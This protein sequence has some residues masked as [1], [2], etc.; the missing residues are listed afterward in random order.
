MDRLQFLRN[1]PKRVRKASTSTRSGMGRKMVFRMPPASA[2]RARE[3]IA[4]D[5]NAAEVKRAVKN[6]G[7]II[8]EGN[9]GRGAG[10]CYLPIQQS[11]SL[12]TPVIILRPGW[13][14]E[15]L[16]HEFT[17]HLRFMDDTRGG[18]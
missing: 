6:G 17:H 2:E 4:R 8:K 7:I 14:E 11:S 5:F 18:D 16:V 9:P 13:D 3:I 1:I 10:G 12:K 15:T